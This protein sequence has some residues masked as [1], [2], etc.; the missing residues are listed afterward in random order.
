MIGGGA[1]LGQL[2]AASARR[3]RPYPAYKDSGVEWLGEIPEELEQLALK[4]F[5]DPAQTGH[6]RHRS[7]RPR[8]FGRC[9]LHTA[10]GH[11]R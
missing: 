1:P 3:F 10:S 2:S 11:G 5:V 7:V 4:R 8:L 6:V 9:A